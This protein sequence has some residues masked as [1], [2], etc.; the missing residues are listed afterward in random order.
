MQVTQQI[1]VA[2]EWVGNARDEVS[3]KVQSRLEAKKAVGALR[4]EKESLSEK[5]KEAL[6]AHDSAEASLK[7]TERQVEDMRQKL[8]LIKINLATE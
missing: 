2:E 7:T 5:V 6:Q 8:H 3:A 4:Q 1:Y